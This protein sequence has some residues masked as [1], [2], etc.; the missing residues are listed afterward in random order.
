MS[1][2]ATDEI[3]VHF[4]KRHQVSPHTYTVYELTKCL[5]YTTRAVHAVVKDSFGF[6][7][8]SVRSLSYDY[9]FFEAE[10]TNLISLYPGERNL[11]P[12]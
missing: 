5:A 2:I 6:V 7:K 8:L 3:K 4:N 12:G 11:F 10:S 1:R 9:C